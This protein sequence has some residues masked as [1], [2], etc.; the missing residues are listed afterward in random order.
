MWIE[1]RDLTHA[2]RRRARRRRRV[3]ARDVGWAGMKDRHAVTRQW[4]SLPPPARPSRWPGST[5]AAARPLA[6]TRHRH[7]LR[8][9][10]LAG[11]ASPSSCATW[12]APRP[13]PPGPR[14]PG[15]AGA[16]AP[17]WYAEQ[18]FGRD[19]DNAQRGLALIRAGGRGG[20]PRQRRFLVSALQSYLFY[21]WLAARLDDGLLAVVLAGDVLQKRASGGLFTS[22]DPD[23]DGARLAA[24]ELAITG[25]MFGASMRAPPDGSPAHAREAAL[26]AELDLGPATFHA[27]RAI[28]PGTRRQATVLLGEPAVEVVADAAD[29]IRVAF[30]LPAGAYATAV[31][32]EVMKPAAEPPE[33]ARDEP[34]GDPAGARDDDPA[35]TRDDDPDP[36]P[37]PLADGHAV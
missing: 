11:N 19:G 32:R 30:T 37:A 3:P 9:G 29:A 36:A 20:A 14:H 25:P 13:P 5:T 2:G 24:G 15:C 27:V 21:R 16:G 12:P 17:N 34:A 23:T 18:R 7:K 28:A 4:L 26:L 1:K 31:M 8:T 22:T 33:A 35:G 6:V 10:H